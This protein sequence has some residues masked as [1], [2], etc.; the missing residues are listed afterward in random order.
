MM[1]AVAGHS[2][3][4]VGWVRAPRMCWGALL[5]PEGRMG[6]RSW[7]PLSRPGCWSPQVGGLPNMTS[8]IYSNT[9][10]DAMIFSACQGLNEVGRQ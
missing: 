5:S 9:I 6:A 2:E 3:Q 10:P 4:G 1:K 8:S 7:A